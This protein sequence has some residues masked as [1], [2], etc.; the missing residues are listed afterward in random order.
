[1]Q[2]PQRR[3]S[4]LL[5]DE[6][7]QLVLELLRAQAYKCG[8]DLTKIVV[9]TEEK[10]KDAGC[11]GWSPAPSNPDPW[12]GDVGTC[13]Q[14]KAGDAGQPARIAKEV[15]KPIPRKTLEDGGRFVV[16][17]SG[18][19]NG[20][21]GERARLK[22]LRDVAVANG[23]PADRIEVIGSERLTTWCNENP[24]VASQWA[25]RP[26]GVWRLSK[27]TQAAV[28]QVA[29]QST[30]EV[31]AR[32]TELH[33]DLD[34]QTGRYRHVHVHGH[35]GVG[36]TRFVL[37]LCR[38]AP[39]KS[40][41]VHIPQAVDVPVAR[42]IDGVVAEPDA[43]LVIVVDEV[44]YDQLRPLRDA[45]D[46]GE[47][48]VRLITIGH[49]DS[50]DP[51]RI[52]PLRVDPLAP[53][54]LSKIVLG[55][56]PSMPREHV[57]FVVGFADG[58]VRLAKLAADA[59]AKDPSVDVRGLLDQAHI[60]DFLDK[61]LGDGRRRS[62]YVVAALTSVGW[63][64]DREDEGRVIAAHLGMDWGEVQAD[65]EDFHRRFGIVPRGGRLRYLSPTPLA[66]HLAVEAWE[67]YPD[68][69]RS[70]PGALPNDLAREAYYERLQTIAK[71]PQARKFAREELGFFFKAAHFIDERA[72]RRWSAL[73]F[74]D[75]EGAARNIMRAMRD[76][77]IE[78]RHRI[79]DSARSELVWAL[80][81][82]AWSTDSFR[83]A[84][85]SLAFLAEAENASWSNNATGEFVG[86]F[87]VR[88]GGTAVPYKDRLPV[89]DELLSYGRDELDKLVVRA[90]SQVGNQQ[91]TRIGGP[92]VMD[93]APEPEW[94]PKTWGEYFE[95][96]RLACNR[97][98][99][100]ARA[101]PRLADAFVEAAPHMA[102]LL[103]VPPVRDSVASFYR[104]LR[105][106]FPDTR[107]GLRREV[108][109]IL[110]KERKYWRELSEAELAA[111]DALHAEFT[112]R[113]LAGRLRHFVGPSIWD[114]EE[115]ADLE[116]LATDLLN[117]RDAL[118]REWTWLTSGE[119]GEGW[120]LGETLAKVDVGGQLEREMLDFPNRGPDFRLIGAY[121]N[122][123]R[124]QQGD[125]W[126]DS[127]MEEL[128]S[129]G[130][131]EIP[132]FVDLFW[133]SGATEKTATIFEQ[134][135]KAQAVEPR[136]LGQLGFGRWQENLSKETLLR[137]FRELVRSGQASAAAAV[138]VHRV[139]QK[140][141]EKDW[142][143]SFGLELATDPELIRSR[144]MASYYWKQIAL[145]LI[146]EYPK[147]IV[148][149]I[150][151]EQ[152]RKDA[153]DIWFAEFSDAK[154]VLAKAISLW[155]D[156]V[157]GLIA[158][159]LSDKSTRARF[160]IGFPSGLVDK[161]PTE[162]ILK[163]I[164]ADPTPRASAI[165]GIAGKDYSADST[166][167]SQVLGTFGHDPALVSSFFSHFVSGSWVGEASNHWDS[168]ASQL[169]EVAKHTRLPKL[170]DWAE[171]SAT[172]LRRM[173]DEDRVREEEEKIRGR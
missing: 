50:P 129:R 173:A 88:L 168:L 94:H 165:A 51:A 52:Q 75:P 13:W 134:L 126:F 26:E 103:R 11:D 37:E 167:A 156:V 67:T 138:L 120:R 131:N 105:A 169:E 150:L 127:W 151:K 143:N 166:L 101:N 33:R 141:E 41:V 32:I 90:L 133:R 4:L 63:S 87:Q 78:E 71:N 6:L 69:M 142:W 59:V 122:A 46:Y 84:T 16:V 3:I 164:E 14:F 65:V 89:L 159:L 109:E 56:H 60:R 92:S 20:A 112:D 12:L 163:W 48:R 161:I 153:T 86:R 61:M 117:D 72:T 74:A 170:R 104:T 36:K 53:E 128:H 146:S 2:V 77:S 137:L 19:T 155:P 100:I 144:H 47:G 9:N 136:L 113:S 38:N 148:S 5:D 18:S 98:E 145:P 158:P 22:A 64:E 107:E 73:T 15:L 49:S 93:Q 35:P 54:A 85:L 66:I 28:H 70:L 55:W 62:L 68:R 121:I 1:M 79:A 118:R 39:W 119:A 8:A 10:A 45:I 44:Q 149:A 34:L 42:L 23:I 123:R 27:W 115:R 83:N 111:L 17:A 91:E 116:P 29:W 139:K 152:V 130:T 43:A 157:W 58:Y 132:L 99:N 110:Q 124:R 57:E 82:L 21:E 96:I 160:Q 76:A 125:A 40:F 25:G 114:E 81:R 31:D 102:M 30:P 97:L 172:K 140:P 24:S 154:E 7:D 95:C 80:V 171:A 147:E 135:L 106:T 162:V 108:A